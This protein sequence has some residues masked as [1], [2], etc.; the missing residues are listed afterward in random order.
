MVVNADSTISAT[1]EVNAD[2]TGLPGAGGLISFTVPTLTVTGTLHANGGG[3]VTLQACSLTLEPA[4]QV[5][6]TGLGGFTLLQAS[7]P[8]EIDG[9]LVA[10][11]TNTLD[12]LDPAHLPVVNSASISPDPDVVENAP[13]V[14]PLCPG[15]VTTTTTTSP[16][17]TTTAPPTATTTA[18]VATTTT[19]TSSTTTVTSTT[20]PETTTSTTSTTI[21][22]STTTTSTTLATCSPAGCDDRL[23][24]MPGTCVDGVCQYAPVSGTA[25]ATI[26][27][28]Q[29]RAG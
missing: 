13:P 14:S 23:P 16:V 15:Q 28:D 22:P 25:C 11:S 2:D 7:G 5:L 12:Y 29:I 20:A 4:G 1:G 8:M 6:A 19:T 17:T 21:A 10:G 9:T 24:C 26:T 27:L 18:T 3:A